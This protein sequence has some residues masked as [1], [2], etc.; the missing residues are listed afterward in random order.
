MKRKIIKKGENMR[1]FGN[2][3]HTCPFLYC[4]KLLT[5][6]IFFLLSEA[7]KQKEISSVLFKFSFFGNCGKTTN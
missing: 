7:I 2:V 6:N 5:K 1:I 4:E 3:R